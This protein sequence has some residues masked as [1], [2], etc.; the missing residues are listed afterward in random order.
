[1][2]AWH[3]ELISPAGPCLLPPGSDSTLGVAP[4]LAPFAAAVGAAAGVCTDAFAPCAP[5][6]PLALSLAELPFDSA[7][8]A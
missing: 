3:G 5:A 1:M 2:L 8:P 7:A 4:F 6:G